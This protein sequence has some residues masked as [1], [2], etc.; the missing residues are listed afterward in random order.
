METRWKR[1]LGRPKQWWID[2]A[3]YN[4]MEIGTRDG[5]TVPQDSD[6]WTEVRVTV[7]GLNDL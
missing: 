2:N 7:M 5:E 3:E 1:P 6:I 4:P